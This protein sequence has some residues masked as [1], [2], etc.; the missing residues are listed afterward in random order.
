[1]KKFKIKKI[2]FFL[3]FIL[4]NNDK[5]NGQNLFSEI[6]ESKII[7]EDKSFISLSFSI[8]LPISIV[9]KESVLYFKT[10]G[11]VNIEKKMI[12]HNISSNKQNIKLTTSI[13][14]INKKVIINSTSKNFD[15]NDKIRI[16]N[17]FEGIKIILKRKFFQDHI[18]ALEKKIKILN[19]KQNRLIILQPKLLEKNKNFFYRLYLKNK[20]KKEIYSSAI[21][22]M[23]SKLEFYKVLIKE[24]IK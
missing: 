14:K 23:Y 2:L 8:G 18:F 7:I 15:K 21:Q 6:K 10:L 5:I 1:M 16:K 20:V 19:R 9:K 3:F 24:L 4:N 12:Y 22:K 13:D 11:E 17:L